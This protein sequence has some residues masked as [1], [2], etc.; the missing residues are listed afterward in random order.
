MKHSA[1]RVSDREYVLI[2]EDGVIEGMTEVA[3]ETQEGA[4][5]HQDPKQIMMDLVHYRTYAN[6]LPSGRKET[7]EEVISR[8]RDMHTMKFP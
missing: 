6:T 2:K 1:S 7:R 3:M 4:A 8:V 5:Y